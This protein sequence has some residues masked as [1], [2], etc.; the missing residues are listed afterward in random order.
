[1]QNKRIKKPGQPG[2]L[3]DKKLN[4]VYK[5]RVAHKDRHLDGIQKIWKR[6][7]IS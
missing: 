3:V 5:Q 6:L 7:K 2:F 4:L 1:M